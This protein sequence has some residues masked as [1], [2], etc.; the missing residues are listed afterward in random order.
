[1]AGGLAVADALAQDVE[2]CIDGLS[3]GHLGGLVLPGNVVADAYEGVGEDEV[4]AG[5]VADVVVGIAARDGLL[6]CF[7]LILEETAIVVVLPSS[8]GE[9]CGIE[10]T[11]GEDA[12]LVELVEVVVQLLVRRDDGDAWTHDAEVEAQALAD[13]ADVVLEGFG[14]DAFAELG[15]DVGVMELEDAQIAVDDPVERSVVDVEGPMDEV[16]EG[17]GRLVVVEV[18][19][20]GDEGIDV[21]VI[22]GFEGCG[23]GAGFGPKGGFGLLSEQD[24]GLGVVADGHEVDASFDGVGCTRDDVEGD[25]ADAQLLGGAAQHLG[26]AEDDGGEELEHLGVLEDFD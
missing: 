7:V 3:E 22:V 9:G 16:G 26:A 1:M 14:S 25:H 18:T 21:V 20:E 12:L 10:G 15:G 13:G 23:E 24:F 2:G 6:E 11:E 5:D 17:M 19:W 4:K 8:L